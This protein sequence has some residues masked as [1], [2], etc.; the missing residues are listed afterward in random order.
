ML[1]D[2]KYYSG[3]HKPIISKSDFDKA[4]E[5]LTDRSRPRLKKLFFPLRGF[6]KCEVCGCALTASLKKGHHY[7]YCTNRREKCEEHKSYMRET[8]LYSIFANVLGNLA[9]SE[10]KIELMYK[11][12]KEKVGIDSEY[13]DTALATLQNTLDG[14]KTREAKLLDTF[15]VEQISKE[16]YDQKVL[17]TQNERISLNKQIQE[18]KNKQPASMLE[19]TKEIFLQGSRAMKEFLDGDDFKK[20]NILENLCWNLSFK[21]KN[22]AQL[23]LKS[24]FDVLYKAPKNGT[25]HEMLAVWDDIRTSLVFS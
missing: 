1:R 12:A 3:N 8:Y 2:G 4:K 13:F 9:F 6:M 11:A 19:P 7:Y 10:R 5:L 17:D 24:P 15:L 21:E 25:L 18:L 22:V 14:L 20:R 16:L 23:K